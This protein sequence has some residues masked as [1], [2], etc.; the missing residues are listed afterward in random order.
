M[1]DFMNE[2]TFIR[3]FLPFFETEDVDEDIGLLNI[4]H[5]NTMN[6]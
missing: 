4:R 1:N 5:L 6:E 2:V 3:L